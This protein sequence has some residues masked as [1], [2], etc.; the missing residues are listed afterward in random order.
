MVYG[1]FKFMVIKLVLSIKFQGK[2][3]FKNEGVNFKFRS[4]E[5]RGQQV[6]WKVMLME[7]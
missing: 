1:E 4:Q 6:L 5:N 2:G 3:K 7:V